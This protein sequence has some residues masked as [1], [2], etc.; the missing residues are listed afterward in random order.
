MTSESNPERD[1]YFERLEDFKAILLL[2]LDL[3]KKMPAQH[4]DEIALRYC[5]SIFNKILS[6]GL[7]L[8][9]IIPSKEPKAGFYWDIS[10]MSALSR[11]IMEAY[12]ALA[13]ISLH[14]ITKTEREFR[15]LLWTANDFDRRLKMFRTFPN[16]ETASATVVPWHAKAVRDL[17][18]S[19]FFATLDTNSKKK[20]LK[21]LPP[22]HNSQADRNKISGISDDY[23]RMANLMLSQ[24]VHTYSFAIHHLQDHAP[25]TV[26]GYRN[27]NV[28]L[29]HSLSFISRA[30]SEITKIYLPNEKFN[31][32][33]EKILSEYLAFSQVAA[34]KIFTS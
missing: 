7:S 17:E 15:A 34:P 32:E 28:A 10:S 33:A 13:Y 20:L 31:T 8:H 27:L 3:L 22:F 11:C 21:E 9:K 18:N 14:P 1:L 5:F 2:G 16:Y 12:D 6:H 19:D 30:I 25:E 29:I 24:Y 4:D 26:A 23:Y